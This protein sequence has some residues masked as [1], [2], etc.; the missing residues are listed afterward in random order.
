MGVGE[1]SVS[2]SEESERNFFDARSLYEDFHSF[3]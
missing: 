1:S 2:S 3:S